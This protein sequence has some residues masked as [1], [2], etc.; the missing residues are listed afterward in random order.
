MDR[1]VI[2]KQL[3]AITSSVE[4]VIIEASGGFEPVLA[5]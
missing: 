3:A 5:T 4:E 1:G 2:A